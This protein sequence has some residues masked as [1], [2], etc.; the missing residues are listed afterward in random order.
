MAAYMQKKL[1][2]L[3][4]GMILPRKLAKDDLEATDISISTLQAEILI[5]Q[6]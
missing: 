5:L 2:S 6:T 3:R 4:I 1:L